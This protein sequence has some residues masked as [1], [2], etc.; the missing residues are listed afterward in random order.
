MMAGAAP[1][2]ILLG[3]RASRPPCSAERALSGRDAR[4]PSGG[5]GSQGQRLIHCAFLP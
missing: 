4:A 3:A 5:E 2:L 1:Y